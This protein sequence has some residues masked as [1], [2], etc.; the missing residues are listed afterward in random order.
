MKRTETLPP[1][2]TLFGLR[3]GFQLCEY[4]DDELSEL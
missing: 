4:A 1:V 3:H 2:A